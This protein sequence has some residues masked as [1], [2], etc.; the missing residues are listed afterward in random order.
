MLAR[1]TVSTAIASSTDMLIW[2]HGQNET[3]AVLAR[4]LSPIMSRLVAVKCEFVRD[5][6]NHRLRFGRP[7]MSVKL[8]KSQKLCVFSQGQVFGYI[9]W[10]A[11]KYGTIDWRL[12][13]CQVAMSARVTKI[14]GIIPGA[15]ILLSV[16]GLVAM[17]RMLKRID[18]LETQSG[19]ALETITP[20]Y[21]RHLQNAQI[22]N[23]PAHPFNSRRL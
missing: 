1:V 5:T 21:W 15:T 20:A 13:I 7:V 9:R 11:N 4:E 18:S 6:V 16:H 8:R 19:G 2:T 3:T 23:R 14:P 22:I 12:Y 17:Q 10:K